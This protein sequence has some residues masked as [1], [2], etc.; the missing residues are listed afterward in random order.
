MTK[1]EQQAENVRKMLLAMAKD[2]RVI[3]IKLADRLHNLRTLKFKSPEKQKEKAKETFDIYA[4]LAHRLGISKI[5]W[6]LEDLA[7]RY[8]HPDEYYDLVKQI[9]EKRVER[10]AYIKKVMEDLENNLDD[11]GIQA[12]IDGRPKHFYSIYRKMVNKNKTLDQI[13]DLTAIRVLV[14]TVKDCY[15]VLGIVHTIYKPIPGRFKDYIAMPKPNMYQ[16][17]HTTVIGA[18]GKTFEIQIR[19]FEMHKTAE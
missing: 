9:A 18:Q 16:S 15:A 6:E 4:P 7:F 17:L 2:I 14:G 1:E 5:K 19:T 8:L 10:E 12:D 11:A 13:F 3:I